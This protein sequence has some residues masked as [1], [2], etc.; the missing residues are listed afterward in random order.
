MTVY[1]KLGLKVPK[2]WDEFMAN[3]AKIK[4]AGI[5][6]VSRPTGDTWTSQLF[7]LG[8]YHNVAG[9][10]MPASR[11]KYT[12]EQ[13]EV[14][15]HDPAVERFPAHRRRSRTPGYFNKDFGSAKLN[16]GLKAVATG[17]AA[18]YP[19]ADR[20]RS[21]TIDQ[22][23][24]DKLNDVGFFALPGTTQPTNGMTVWPPAARRLHPQDDRGRQAR[25][26]QEVPGF[27]ATQEGC[28]A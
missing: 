8:D 19:H 3:N 18:Q 17:K 23:D 2:T 25:A 6:P 27:V 7:V 15:H 5:D 11:S 9:R 13:G 1:K 16:D 20:S 14:R 22:A 24:P 26:R 12:E 10:R 21:P 28:D 4:A